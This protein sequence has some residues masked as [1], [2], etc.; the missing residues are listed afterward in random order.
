MTND[1]MTDCG[2]VWRPVS[3]LSRRD[4][5]TQ[6]GVLT[7]GTDKESARPEGA[8]DIV[9]LAHLSM[10]ALGTT[11]YRPFSTSNPAAAGCNSDLAQYS[12]T[13]ILHHSAWPDSRTTTTTRTST[14]SLVRA[15]HLM[16]VFLGLKPQAES[17]CP[18]GAETKCSGSRFSGRH[19]NESRSWRSPPLSPL[20]ARFRNSPGQRP[21]VCRNARDK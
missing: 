15:A 9:P 20:R 18:F 5:R 11:L 4:N 13:P 16:D 10:Q 19:E 3:Y 6:P 12:H 17:Y 2:Y 14:K 21:N 8:E 1:K 7:P